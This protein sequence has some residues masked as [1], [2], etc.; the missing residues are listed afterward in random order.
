MA[1]RILRQD[2]P[3]PSLVLMLL[4]AAI[5]V[6]TL[7]FVAS[8]SSSAVPGWRTSVFFASLV[9]LSSTA[10]GL[11]NLRLRTH[12]FGLALR[13][14]LM[15][16]MAFA[17]LLLG[18]K[19]F[20][21]SRLT[22]GDYAL[23]LILV[24]LLALLTR[25]LL[26]QFFK[27]GFLKTRILVYGAGKGAETIT[28]LRRRTDRL[29]FTV[30]GYLPCNGEVQ[31]IPKDKIVDR[32]EDLLEY[33]KRNRIDEIVVAIDDRR[34]SFPMDEL[35]HCRVHGIDIIDIV[36]FLE[37]ETGAL[38]LD[39]LRPSWMIFSPGF[40]HSWFRDSIRRML[41]VTT[42]LLLLLLGWPLMLLAAI[43]IKCEDGWHAPVLYR[44][45]R[46]G[47]DGRRFTVLKFRS[48]K[49]DAE[50]DG[51]PRWASVEDGRVTHVGTWLRPSRIDELPQL[52]NVLRG[53]M[54]F[55]GPRPERPEFV[56]EFDRILPYYRERHSVAPG[57]TGWAQ[58]RYSYGASEKDALEKLKY[59]LYYVKHHSIVF[60]LVIMIQTVEVILFGR[61][62]R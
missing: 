39:L 38:R 40:E 17:A 30:V 11:Y 37:R 18:L 33:C 62:A 21:A 43:A 55:V 44:Q 29:C 8:I 15:A 13:Y 16:A 56:S 31:T 54:R 1:I 25:F 6:A 5:A 35:L 26:S 58:L 57:L 42:S 19:A 28:Q 41:D 9:V 52:W 12:Q 22:V 34:Q 61:G 32:G 20:P 53:D 50:A 7:F 48:M 24:V 59:D 46:V 23:A 45:E 14:L 49:V 27:D 36:G 60:D 3:L 51:V 2:V 10:M 4:E 47:K